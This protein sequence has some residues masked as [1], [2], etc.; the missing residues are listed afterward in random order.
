MQSWFRLYKNRTDCSNLRCIQFKILHDRLS[1]SQSLFQD[2]KYSEYCITDIDS[3]TFALHFCPTS[4]HLWRKFKSGSEKIFI[5]C[6]L[7][8]N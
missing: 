7:W 1:E 5:P 3:Q 6:M 8:D 4:V 2:G